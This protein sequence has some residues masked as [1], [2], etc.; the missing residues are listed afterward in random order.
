[1]ASGTDFTRKGHYSTYAV[2]QGYPYG[3]FDAPEFN[4]RVNGK[5]Y[6]GLYDDMNQNASQMVFGYFDFANGK[7]QTVEV[8]CKEAFDTFRI[9]PSG[10]EVYDVERI[11]PKALSFKI[12]KAMQNLTFVFDEKYRDRGVLHLFCNQLEEQ[13]TGATHYF[14]P[15][16]HNLREGGGSGNI[17]IKGDETVYI[18]A[19]AVVDG[20]ITN[21]R[22]TSG[23]VSGH[24][25]LVN[26]DSRFRSLNNTGCTGGFV[27]DIIINSRCNS[28][29]VVFHH[30][31]DMKIEGLRIVS[32]FYRSNDGVD[33]TGC[34]DLT[35]DNCFIRAA[36]DCVA[37]KGLEPQATVAAERPANVGLHFNRMQLWS[38]SNNAFGIGAETR[39]AEYRDISLTNSDILFDWD[40]IF[41]SQRMW[42]QSAL[43]INAMEGTYIS[44][45]LFENIRV[46]HGMRLTCLGWTDDFYF[47]CIKS[48]QS[49]PGEIRNVTF[50]NI[51]TTGNTCY[52]NTDEIRVQVWHGNGGT[53][54]KAIHGVT[55]ENVTLNG[56]PLT[57]FDNRHVI[58]NDAPGSELLYDFNFINTNTK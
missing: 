20:S 7:E 35:F 31:R 30:C 37:I 24:G 13:Q 52:P 10:A 4:V 5:G 32:A 16:Y 45:I 40:D 38:D 2:P 3:R 14:G 34:S 53:P 55:F 9:L 21:A 47:G 33:I 28:W 41:N 6:C 11:G 44:D 17:T 58:A 27:R 57:G 49:D 23:G 56:E 26:S 25:V 22:L 54:R 12:S 51:A 50:R 29:Q 42:Y 8:V 36:D 19:G 15:G 43:N 46:N 18:A 39:A 48:D 1:M